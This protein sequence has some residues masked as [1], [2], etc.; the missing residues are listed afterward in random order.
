MRITLTPKVLEDRITVI[1]MGINQRKKLILVNSF[2][3]D[4]LWC[5]PQR[6]DN[7]L[8][9]ILERVLIPLKH[10]LLGYRDLN[11]VVGTPECNLRLLLELFDPVKLTTLA[12]CKLPLRSYDRIEVMIEGHWR[13]CHHVFH[14][15]CRLQPLTLHRDG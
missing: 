10:S 8:V 12:R 6:T 2:I 15:A 3:G 5:R 11:I 9:S 4:I 1:E 14:L 7:P 13:G